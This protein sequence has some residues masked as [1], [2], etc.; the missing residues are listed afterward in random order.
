MKC[1]QNRGVIHDCSQEGLNSRPKS[2]SDGVC[3]SLA[4]TV[5]RVVAPRTE[6][7]NEASLAGRSWKVTRDDE[8]PAPHTLKEDLKSRNSPQAA[9]LPSFP[10]VFKVKVSVA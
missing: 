3:R 4:Q 7:R 5:S 8:L 10:F 1:P 2:G 9:E 6:E